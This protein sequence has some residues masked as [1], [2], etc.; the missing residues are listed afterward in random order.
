MASTVPRLGKVV[1][2][3]KSGVIPMG[4]GGGAGGGEGGGGGC[5]GGGARA[6]Y[7]SESMKG[8]GC[9]QNSATPSGMTPSS[10]STAG[11]RGATGLEQSTRPQ[12][13]L[14]A[15][16]QG[17]LVTVCAWAFSPSMG[18]QGYD[19]YQSEIHAFT[20]G[21]SLYANCKSVQPRQRSTKEHCICIQPLSQRWC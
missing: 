6:K 4:G 16:R 1:V 8:P 18:L 5:G 12:F 14:H 3:F 9:T 2:K 11:C 13:W 20:T 17:I 15:R 19:G 7:Q 10:V 21:G